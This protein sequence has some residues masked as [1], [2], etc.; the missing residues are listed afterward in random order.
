M[1]FFPREFNGNWLTGMHAAFTEHSGHRW[2]VRL[3]GNY[4]EEKFIHVS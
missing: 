2:A 4:K 1:W 3:V